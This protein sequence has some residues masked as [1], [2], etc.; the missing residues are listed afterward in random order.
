MD[1]VCRI[2]FAMKSKL[3]T[4][5]FR[6]IKCSLTISNQHNLKRHY[7]RVHADNGK[8]SCKECGLK[9][10][11]EQRYKEHEAAHSGVALYK[12]KICF[13]QFM[14]LNALKK[15]EKLHQDKKEYPCDVPD[16]SEVFFK[17]SLLRKHKKSKH[18]TGEKLISN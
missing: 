13:K 10:S 8:F 16:C 3:F 9:F 18:V 7:E 4:Q 15:H 17:W 6:C 11:K 12:C 1:D 2:V 14:M 5:F